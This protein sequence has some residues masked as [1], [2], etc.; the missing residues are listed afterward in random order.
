MAGRNIV[1][2]SWGDH[3]KFGIDDGQLATPDA[4]ARRMQAWKSELNAG[5]V[6]W[7][8]IQQSPR[9]AQRARDAPP[10]TKPMPDVAWDE[11]ERVPE[12][13][14]GEGMKAYLYVTI[15]DEGWPLLRASMR[16]RSYHNAFHAQHRA[17]QTEFAYN[18]PEFAA[19]D[20]AGWRRHRGVMNLAYPAVRE[21][22]E[23]LFLSLLERGDF[24]GLFICLRSQSRPADHADQHG[25]NDPV[26]SDFHS[27]YGTDIRTEDFDKAQWR[28][29][30]GGYLTTFLCDLKRSLRAGRIK[31]AVG[32]ARGDIIGPPL[33]NAT[34]D[35]RTWV[36]EG[37]VDQLVIDQNSSRC[38]SMWLNLWPMHRGK[39]YLQNYLTGE[40]LPPLTDHLQQ[41]YGPKLSGG[42]TKLFLA[43]QWHQRHAAE[44]RALLAID[45]VSGLVFGSFRHDNAHLLAKGD[46]WD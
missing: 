22:F 28:D 12:I 27:R 1:S 34:L 44:E 7:R 36:Q 25:F 13:A 31:L 38:P 30:Q 18:H 29:M 5:Q 39:G 26:R 45:Q 33:G 40:G 2:V 23:Q 46:W 14:H 8:T 11:L 32:A 3:L 24:D 16:D 9:R 21:H 43:R 10:P 37:I 19:V 41:I 17:S 20:R 15:F 4:V 42:E 6:L 35:W